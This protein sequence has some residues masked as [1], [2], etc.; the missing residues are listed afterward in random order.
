VPARSRRRWRSSALARTRAPASDRPVSAST[1]RTSVCGSALSV[2]GSSASSS[3]GASW[4]SRV[5]GAKSRVRTSSVTLLAPRSGRRPQGRVRRRVG[6]AS[7]GLSGRGIDESRG[8]RAREHELETGERQVRPGA[9]DLEREARAGRKGH[10]DALCVAART[11]LGIPGREL[12]P[13][14]A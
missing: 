8:R 3:P 7:L 5:R 6:D 4:S 11:A 14:L 12:I 13:A 10:L 1:T 9:D 2:I